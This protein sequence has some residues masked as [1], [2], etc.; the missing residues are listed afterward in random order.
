MKRSGRRTKHLRTA[1]GCLGLMVGGNAAPA[2]S[3]DS[4]STNT[5]E[6]EK[7][8]KEFTPNKVK[9]TLGS[10]AAENN[11]DEFDVSYRASLIGGQANP[12]CLIT[13]NSN[14]AGAQIALK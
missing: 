13:T 7:L 5:S 4:P 10:P 8:E 14:V 9:I 6:P 1:D 12:T 11:G 2:R 3:T